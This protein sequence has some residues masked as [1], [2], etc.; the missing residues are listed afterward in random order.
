MKISVVIP[1]LNEAETIEAAITAALAASPDAHGASS[2]AIEV[3]V[4]DGGSA[5]AS[6]EKAR[7]LG[8]RVLEAGCGRAKQLQAGVVAA[9]GEVVLFLH[10]DT[11]LAPGYAQA[12]AEALSRDEVVGGAFRFA[13]D[14]EGVGFRLIE[15]GTRLRN[16]IWNSP[17]CDQAI[18]VRRPV[19]AALGGVPQTPIFED[20]D[21]VRAMKQMGRVVI[22]S[23]PALT[24]ARRYVRCGLWKTALCHRAAVFAD[25]I[26]VD[27]ERIAAWLRERLT[28]DLPARAFADAQSNF[29]SKRDP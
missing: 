11:R 12:I 17:Y 3:I 25:G 24:S 21:L 28:S 9:Q 2:Y 23:L 16:W 7:G 26:G 29:E 15:W 13:L 4:V 18:F 27:R 1:V 6:R 8:A 22:V 10:A 20:A 19:L 5:D 14:A